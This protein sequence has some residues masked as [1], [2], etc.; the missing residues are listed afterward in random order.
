MKYCILE[1]QAHAIY[2]Y[3]W[4]PILCRILTQS[5]TTDNSIKSNIN[6]AVGTGFK[7]KPDKEI[8]SSILAQHKKSKGKA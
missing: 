1:N 3:N 6:T 8:D 4:N 5:S 7:Y 2:I